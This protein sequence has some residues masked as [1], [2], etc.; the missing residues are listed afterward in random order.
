MRLA[1]LQLHL[2]RARWLE[3]G[4]GMGAPLRNFFGREEQMGQNYLNRYLRARR[5]D[6]R[7]PLSRDLI[8]I[9]SLL[10]AKFGVVVDVAAAVAVAEPAGLAEFGELAASELEAEWYFDVAACSPNSRCLA[11]HPTQTS[12]ARSPR[13]SWSLISAVVADGCT[14]VKPM[15][16]AIC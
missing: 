13:H 10:T 7:N 15:K 4:L 1:Q 2:R 16:I 8:L 11:S 6:F 5:V 9:S 14:R 12:T 3:V